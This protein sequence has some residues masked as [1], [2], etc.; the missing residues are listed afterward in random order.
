MIE[1]KLAGHVIIGTFTSLMIMVTLYIGVLWLP[2]SIFTEP[3]FLI[4][5]FVL[6]AFGTLLSFFMFEVVD[7]C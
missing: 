2:W 1:E 5:W 3:T 4:I 7:G 6:V